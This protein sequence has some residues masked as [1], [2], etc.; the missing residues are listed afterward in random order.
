MDYSLDRWGETLHDIQIYLDVFG[1]PLAINKYALFF[2]FQAHNF[3]RDKQP[4][5]IDYV[6]VKEALADS[7]NAQ[8][9]ETEKSFTFYPSMPDDRLPLYDSYELSAMARKA[10]YCQNPAINGAHTAAKQHYKA[11]NWPKSWV[12]DHLTV[13][14]HSIDGFFQYSNPY[15]EECDSL[16][17]CMRRV[18]SEL[19]PRLE[20]E[21][22]ALSEQEKDVTEIVHL[23]LDMKSHTRGVNGWLEYVVDAYKEDEATLPRGMERVLGSDLQLTI[24]EI[25]T[26]L[27]RH[28]SVMVAHF[29]RSEYFYYQK[30]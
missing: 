23:L 15:Q 11:A 17:R 10:K 9:E 7:L 12:Y 3:L 20:K 26:L 16:L 13:L 21:Q 27:E 22:C 29:D 4:E 18:K 2:D 30:G 6:A 24:E 8:I 25:C 19:V 1:T 14:I 28:C 5:D